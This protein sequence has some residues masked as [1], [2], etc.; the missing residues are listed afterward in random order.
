MGL[1]NGLQDGEDQKDGDSG[2]DG[3]GGVEVFNL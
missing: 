3:N 1:T 2:V